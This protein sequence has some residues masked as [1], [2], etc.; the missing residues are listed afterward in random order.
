MSELELVI[1]KTQEAGRF[2][3]LVENEFPRLVTLEHTFENN[4]V[5][6]PEGVW[7]CTRTIFH[8]PRVPYAT[9]EIHVPGH[10]RVLFHRG[11][12]EDDSRGCVLVGRRFGGGGILDSALG[13]ADF[14]E[15]RSGLDEFDL[16]V[17]D[18]KAA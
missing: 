4:R 16:R 1:V 10:D 3:V 6:I 17:I 5:V 2:G 7:P 14:M 9:F 8:K 11:N 12:K 13:F 15:R 18:R